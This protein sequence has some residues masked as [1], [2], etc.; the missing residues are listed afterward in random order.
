MGLGPIHCGSFLLLVAFVLLLVASISSPVI[1]NIAL[2]TIKNGNQEMTLG[3]F[4]YCRN[5]HASNHECSNSALGYNVAQVSGGLTDYNWVN[6]SLDHITNAMILTPIACGITAFAALI[7]LCAHRIGFICASFIAFLAFIVSL[8][9]MIFDFV[10]FGIV[11]HEIND[12][13]T[14]SASFSTAIWLTLAAVIVLFFSTFIVFFECCTQGRRS[15]KRSY[16]DEPYA[17][18]G[19][20]GNAAPDMGYAQTRRPWYAFGRNKY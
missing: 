19:Y 10:I 11:K 14:A 8:I 1:D 5:I 9:A 16:N 15:N 12:N 18:N 3:V 13:T 20:V 6:S 17:G 4:G 2:L 7:A